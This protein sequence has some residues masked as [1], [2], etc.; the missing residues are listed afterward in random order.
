MN[1]F[2]EIYYIAREIIA[3]W[4]IVRHENIACVDIIANIVAISSKAHILCI[5]KTFK[6]K[7]KHKVTQN[8]YEIQ[9]E[10]LRAR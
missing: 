4:R 2:R 9:Y 5:Y 1:V 3:I 8:G 10:S 7:L 6:D